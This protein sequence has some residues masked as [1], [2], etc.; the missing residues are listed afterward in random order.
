MATIGADD[1]RVATRFSREVLER[2][3]DRDWTAR[4]GSLD[5]DCRATAAHVADALA[6]YAGHLA[7]R[8]TEWLK[9]DLVPH[10]DASN[11]HVARLIEAIGELLAQAIEATPAEVR[12]FH[13]SGMWDRSGFAAMGSLE[14]LVH[15]GDVAAGLGVAFDPPRGVC[16][17]IIDRLFVGEPPDEDPW[18]VLSWGTGRRDLAGCEPL[19]PDWETYWL[20]RS[21]E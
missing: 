10:A 12:A 17:R 6:F 11:R 3:S 8:A 20:K 7:G 2:M 4:A 21:E 9:F 15:T 19:G 18:R 14:T 16:Q 1:V 13:H 5:W